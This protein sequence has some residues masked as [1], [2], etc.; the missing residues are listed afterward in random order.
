[1]VC[2]TWKNLATLV[3]ISSAACG[4]KFDSDDERKTMLQEAFDVGRRGLGG[5]ASHSRPKILAETILASR[6]VHRNWW[7]NL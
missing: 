3:L 1:L 5:T 2:S 7:S 4:C 6:S